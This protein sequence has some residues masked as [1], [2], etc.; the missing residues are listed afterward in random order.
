VAVVIPCFKQ[1]RYLG[2]AIESVLRQGHAADQI[3]VIDDG[4][5]EDL[6]SVVSSYSRA[7]LIRQ[8]NMGLAAARNRG[9]REITA[10]YVIFLDADDRLLPNA[11][12]AGL[13]CFRDHP[14]A[15]FV[16][17]RFEEQG[18]GSR[19]IRESKRIDRLDLVRCNWIAMIGAVLFDR[20]KLLES[21]GFDE[22]LAMCEDWD[23]YLRLSRRHAFAGHDEVVAVYQRHERSMSA[24]VARLRLWVDEVRNRER[25]RGL[26]MNELRAWKEGERIWDR[27]YGPPA[28]RSLIGRVHRK[29]SRAL[30]GS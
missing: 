4:G 23:V 5:D 8:N 11:I 20:A 30:L 3:I 29:V 17:G 19:S 6:S 28:P 15:A 27:F 10:D 9:L 1:G 2:G 24:D 16:Y 25:R 22:S 12:E 26:S 14:E 18:P 7:K 13:A 21:G